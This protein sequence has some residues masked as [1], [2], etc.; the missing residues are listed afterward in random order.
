VSMPIKI[1]EI[2]GGAGKMVKGGTMAK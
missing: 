1:N 2:D